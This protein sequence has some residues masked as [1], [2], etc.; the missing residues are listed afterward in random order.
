MGPGADRVWKTA[1]YELW[2]LRG[3]AKAPCPICPV[4]P[5]H[6]RKIQTK[7]C[8]RDFHRVLAV[9]SPTTAAMQPASQ[10]NAAAAHP[11]AFSAG[12]LCDPT[13]SNAPLFADFFLP[14]CSH[15][16]TAPL[17]KGHP[18]AVLPATSF[19]FLGQTVEENCL[20]CASPLT[21][22]IHPG[23]RCCPACLSNLREALDNLPHLYVRLHLESPSSPCK[24]AEVPATRLPW[25]YRT[26]PSP[27]RLPLLTHATTCVHAVHT[28]AAHTLPGSLP[29]HPLRPGPLLQHLCQALSAELPTTVRTLDDATDA[30]VTWVAYQ[31]A[32]F[33][34]GYDEPARPLPTPCPNCDLRSLIRLSD[35]AVTCRSC[36][37]HW[38][39]HPHH[40]SAKPP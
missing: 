7:P 33:L 20:L 19:L 32:R 11:C 34:L 21:S 9:R 36:A 14:R 40:G 1:R 8:R 28:W 5:R 35:G 25:K 2:Q 17:G 3:P 39:H 10:N 13:A 38:P 22:T 18:L 15:I 27:L 6:D 23:G 31:R 4:L 16:P 26:A 37:A 30:S 24:S 29:L 12:P